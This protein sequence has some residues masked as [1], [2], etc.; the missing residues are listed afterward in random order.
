MLG[1]CRV[2]ALRHMTTALIVFLVI[3]AFG[4]G[5]ATGFVWGILY[6]AKG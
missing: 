1:A 6:V 3:G 4:V 5:V 2:G